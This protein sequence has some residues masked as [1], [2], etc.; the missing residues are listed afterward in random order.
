MKGKKTGGRQKGSL[1]RTTEEIRNVLLTLLDDSM[2]QLKMD[3]KKM[4][5]KD[6]ATI[7]ISLVRH[8]IPPAIIPEKLTENQMLEIIQHLQNDKKRGIEKSAQ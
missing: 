6:R 8:C 7:I 5:P 4:N 1:N 3:L 2:D